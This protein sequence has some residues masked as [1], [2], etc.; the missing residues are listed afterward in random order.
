MKTRPGTEYDTDHELLAANFKIKLKRL[1]Q[2]ST[3]AR[4][5]LQ[6][7]PS[8]YTV[9]VKSRFA[10]LE[11]NNREPE[12]LWQEICKIVNE[13]KHTYLQSQ[14]GRKEVGSQRTH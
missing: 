5:N 14:Q 2:T 11:S 1:N 6:N 4:L 7:I 13:E 12:E 8:S 3:T 10:G 9:P